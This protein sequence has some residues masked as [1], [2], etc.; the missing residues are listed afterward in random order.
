[1]CVKLNQLPYLSACMNQRIWLVNS[2][3]MS[4]SV[5]CMCVLDGD[6]RTIDNDDCPSSGKHTQ[7]HIHTN[8][9]LILTGAVEPIS[10]FQT[11]GGSW[12]MDLNHSHV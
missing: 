5:A 2:V 9:K 8:G 10:L 12:Q 1:M 3:R 7:S 6:Y 4:I 11:C